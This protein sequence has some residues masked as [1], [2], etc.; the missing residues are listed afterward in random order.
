MTT[1]SETTY[2]RNVSELSPSL[3]TL[4]LGWGL[5][6]AD[7]K[8][9]LGRRLSEWVNG[10]PTLEA[11]VGAAAMTQDELGHARSLYS[12]LRDFPGAPQE[13]STEADLQRTDLFAPASLTTPWD[14]W[15]EVV[16]TNVLFDR[17]LNMVIAATQRSQ[18]GPLSQRAAKIL[19]EERFHRIYGDAWLARLSNSEKETHKRLQRAL[20][21][22]WILADAWIGPQDD[23]VTKNLLEAKI[24]TTPPDKLREL[25]RDEANSVLERHDLSLT[26]YSPDWSQWDPQRREVPLNV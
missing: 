14:S 11:A 4:L 6:L 5:A 21:K 8:Y 9:L 16:A 2:L 24:L 22:A 23:P 18:F 25:W 12:M 13:L 19:Q 7:T 20:E 17:A 15:I 10:A 26:S 1:D 3:S